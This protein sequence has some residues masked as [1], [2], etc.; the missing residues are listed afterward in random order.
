MNSPNQQQQMPGQQP[1]P[2]APGSNPAGAAVGGDNVPQTVGDQQFVSKT[3]ENGMAEVE[4]GQLAA[5]KS[6]SPDVKEYGQKI[7]QVH[8]QIGD[9]LKP[10]AKKLGASEPRGPSRKD[11]KEIA[12]MQTLS[13][14]SFD[15]AFVKAM[16]KDQ[17]DDIKDFKAEAK[18]G[19][20]AAVQQ[21][22]KD[23]EPVLSQHLQILE[24]L[25]KSHNVNVASEE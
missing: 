13:G 22:A 19:H 18:D 7:A 11:K 5:Q 3:L 4:M 1:T 9:Q 15:A 16:M 21:W 25:A 14:P 2:G 12:N 10:V 24:Q 8:E 23:D 6:E 20:V 17:Q